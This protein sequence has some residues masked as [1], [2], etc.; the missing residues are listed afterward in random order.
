MSVNESVT[1][2]TEVTP[3]SRG[4]EKSIEPI[5]RIEEDNIYLLN[6]HCSNNLIMILGRHIINYSN[7][8]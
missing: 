8:I 2:K 5:K 7:N 1:V 6:I 4:G 3:T